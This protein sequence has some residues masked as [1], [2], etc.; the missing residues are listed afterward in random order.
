[1]RN[2]TQ[3]WRILVAGM[4]TATLAVSGWA[5]NA[6]A[7]MPKEYVMK[8]EL[9]E[10]RKENREDHQQILEHIRRLYIEGK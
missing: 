4:I 1:M 6:V 3:L 10:L 5:L 9:K 8:D 7:N 2:H